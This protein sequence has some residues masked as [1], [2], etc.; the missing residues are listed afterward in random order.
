MSK[1]HIL[2]VED[3]FLIARNIAYKLRAAGYQVVDT[4]S[5]GEQAIQIALEHHPDLIVMDIRL[6]GE[7]DGIEAAERIHAQVDIPVLYL[8]A[9]VDDEILQRAKITTPFGYILKPFQD[10]ELFSN[11]EIALFKHQ[12][13]KQLADRE[14]NYRSLFEDS[15]ISLWEEDFSAVK[16]YLEGLQSAGI[17]DLDMYLRT[18]P[19]VVAHCVSLVQIISV[20]RTSLA[21]FEAESKADL[22]RELNNVFVDASFA[23]FREEVLA[24]HNGQSLFETELVICTLKGKVLNVWI[25]IAI[26]P[27]YETTWGK[28]FASVI[29]I[30]QR[31]QA[32]QALQQEQLLL[33]T[34]IDNLPDA[35]YAKDL[36]GRKTLANRVDLDNIGAATE[37]DVLGK[38]DFEL[39][40]SD[41]A[42]HFDANDQQAIQTGQPVLDC[43][44][45]LVNS[46]GREIWLLTSKLPLKTPEGQVVGLVGIGRDISERKRAEKMLRAS[47]TRYRELVECMSSGVA[48]YRA[49]P[50]GED[51]VFVDFNRA[52][53]IIE[54]VRRED[55]LGKRVTEV[56]PNV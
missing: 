55:I 10:H 30:T 47:E 39:F 5:T 24:F 34:V 11:I 44:E 1:A 15:P 53:E 35:I 4:V 26:A 43:E 41:V 49:L 37:E 48:V 42:A 31:T 25:R 20:N 46:Q 51:F 52:G 16:A 8:T 18:H 6:D 56:F 27:G 32:E 36:Q 14:A 38:T 28:V 13:E 9:Y 50:N 3:E 21:L 33:R 54:Q 40:P 17:T 2:V 45:L 12:T 19:D 23:A 22:S 29:D 7:L